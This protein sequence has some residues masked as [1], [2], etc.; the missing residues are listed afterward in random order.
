MPIE[1]LIQHAC[2][3]LNSHACHALLKRASL[4]NSQFS[5]PFIA[6]IKHICHI[7][8]P[9]T[10]FNT[11]TSIPFKHPCQKLHSASLSTPWSRLP[12]RSF[13]PVNH[14][15]PTSRS[16]S[17]ITIPRIFNQYSSIF[18]H[19]MFTQHP[20]QPLNPAYLSNTWSSIPVR[21]LTTNSVHHPCCCQNPATPLNNYTFPMSCTNASILLK[22]WT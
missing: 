3:L 5:F 16:T 20:C 15:K 18:N 14:L 11:W 22:H 17:S 13:T 9:A 6:P 10:L 1:H 7:T 19:V 8:N 12:L 21:N 4:K 2:Q